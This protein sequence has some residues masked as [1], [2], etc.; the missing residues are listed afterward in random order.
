MCLAGV[1]NGILS[2]D[3]TLILWAR[4]MPSTRRGPIASCVVSAC[5]ASIRGWRD[6]VG[7]TAVP[8]SIVLVAVPIVAM[9][10]RA[11]GTP[12]WA[13][14]YEVYPAASASAA[15]STSWA[16]GAL[17]AMRLDPLMPMRIG[18]SCRGS[19]R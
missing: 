17:V 14:Q 9:A 8:I 6:H 15:C 16:R 12:S 1:A 4:P 13:S 19:D 10:V 5:A 11:S 3:S 2:V 7:M 18:A